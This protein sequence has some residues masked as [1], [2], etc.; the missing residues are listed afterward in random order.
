M[1][2]NYDLSKVKNFDDLYHGK[3]HDEKMKAKYECIIMGTMVVGM[4][5]IKDKKD[6]R[7]FYKRMRYHDSLFSENY[8]CFYVSRMEEDDETG[9]RR[10]VRENLTIEDVEDLIGL[11]TNVSKESDA[12]WTKRMKKGFD[13]FMERKLKNGSDW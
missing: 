8:K 9:E 2:L 6:A 1:A 10:V 12:K 4:G 7:I 5:D 3:E 11:H 13:E